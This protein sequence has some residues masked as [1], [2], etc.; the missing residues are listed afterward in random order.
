MIDITV[1]AIFLII[2]LLI[3]FYSS[4][5]IA[6]FSEYA[7]WKR[8][9]GSFAICATLSASFIGGGY[10]M[11]NAAKVYQIGIIYAFGLLGFSLKEIFIA[12]MVAPRMQQYAKCHSVGDMIGIHYGKTAKVITG[13]FSVIICAGI[14]GAQVSAIGTLFSVFFKV[15]V[16][17]G[18]LLGFGV[19]ILYTSLGGM[20]G[21][22]YTDVLQFG[23][24]VIGIPL[25]F[26]F[27]LHAIGGWH[28]IEETVPAA[29]INPFLHDHGTW[30]LGSLVLTFIF[31]E[32]LVPPYVQRLFM[33]KHT[34]QTRQATLA[35]GLLS[36]PIFLI[37]GAIGLIA[38]C[39]NNGLHPNLAIPYVIEQS[40]PVGVRG[41]VI[42][43]LLAVIMS[44]AAG[45][46]NA[47]TISFTNDILPTVKTIH[48]LSHRQLLYIAKTVS[49]VVGIGSVIFALSIHNILDIL[50]YAYNMW[51]PIIVIPLLAAIFGLTVKPFYFYI[52]ALAGLVATLIWSF[53]FHEAFHI[54]SNIVGV[55]ASFLAFYLAYLYNRPIKPQLPQDRIIDT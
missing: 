29:H 47:A 10:V 5:N 40:M 43:G 26:I 28:T 55:L 53:G 4:K 3:G 50:I 18:I 19:I 8:A 21:V 23:L 44:S 31:G 6:N 15:S 48:H 2:N 12:A 20:R 38:Y 52:S 32:I 11:G 14:L 9:F 27:G 42:S 13:I 17:T 7:V 25:I 49:L 54:T 51:S 30:I 39:M 45:F 41:L 33:A 24:I 46:L 35:A 36:I 37:S 22:V 1:I 34:N 16:S